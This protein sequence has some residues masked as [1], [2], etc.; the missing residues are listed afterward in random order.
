MP[1]TQ[2]NQRIQLTDTVSMRSANSTDISSTSIAAS[3]KAL[4]KSAR[5]S[6]RKDRDEITAKGDWTPSAPPDGDKAVKQ[7][8]ANTKGSHVTELRRAGGGSHKSTSSKSRARPTTTIVTQQK[9]FINFG[10]GLRN[11]R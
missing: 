10:W 8:R 3:K 5:P 11:G 1:A 6:T 4:K 7:D 9:L 2:M